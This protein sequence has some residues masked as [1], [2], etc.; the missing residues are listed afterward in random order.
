MTD[1]QLKR[2]RLDTAILHQLRNRIELLRRDG[3]RF[4]QW[5]RDALAR[6]IKANMRQL[7]LAEAKRAKTNG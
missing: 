3:V 5:H 2:L 4:D 7:H 1:S 6:T